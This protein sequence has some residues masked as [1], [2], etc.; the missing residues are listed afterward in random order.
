LIENLFYRLL[1]LRYARAH[2][3]L[4]KLARGLVI[5]EPLGR[6]GFDSLVE[7]NQNT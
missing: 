6:P 3:M 7:S 1:K 5:R 2:N 4:Y